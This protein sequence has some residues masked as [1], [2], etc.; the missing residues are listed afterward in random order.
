MAGPVE[1][2]GKTMNQSPPSKLTRTGGCLVD[3][4]KKGRKIYVRFHH[5]WSRAE[6]NRILRK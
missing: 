4:H 5:F 1:M 3:F 6:I 2:V